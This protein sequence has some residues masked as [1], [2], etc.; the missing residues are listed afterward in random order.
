MRRFLQMF[1]TLWFLFWKADKLFLGGVSYIRMDFDH[2][3]LLPT[4]LF[5]HNNTQSPRRLGAKFSTLPKKE[6]W[7]INVYVLTSK[8]VGWFFFLQGEIS[9]YRS[10]Q[11]PTAWES[12]IFSALFSGSEKK[13]CVGVCYTAAP[14]PLVD[15]R[16]GGGLWQ[17]LKRRT[18]LQV[19]CFGVGRFWVSRIR[20]HDGGIYTKN[21]TLDNVWGSVLS[22]RIFD[23]KIPGGTRPSVLK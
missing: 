16:R 8:P 11:N 14:P 22:E 6:F 13:C 20:K 5:P 1:T 3:F 12:S 2:I 4:P 15:K 10:P 19:L 21:P 18:H 23:P 7:G 9:L 17:G